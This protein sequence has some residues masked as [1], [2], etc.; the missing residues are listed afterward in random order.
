MRVLSSMDG[1]RGGVEAMMGLAV[2][3]GAGECD[4]QAAAGVMSIGVWR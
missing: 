4:A 2:Q 1:S 3:L